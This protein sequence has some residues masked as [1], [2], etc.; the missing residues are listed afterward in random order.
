MDWLR[1]D[2]A[3]LLSRQVLRFHN[4]FDSLTFPVKLCVEYS[5]ID[6]YMTCMEAHGGIRMHTGAYG[7]VAV[8]GCCACLLCCAYFVLACCAVLAVLAFCVCLLCLVA[9]LACCACCAMIACCTCLLRFACLLC[10]L[11]FRLS[12]TP[13]YFFGMAMASI[14]DAL[15]TAQ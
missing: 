5:H 10:W 12:W 8:F 11:A 1:T 2:F 13:F 3:L 15:V 6:T 7:C 4:F 14:L 9:V